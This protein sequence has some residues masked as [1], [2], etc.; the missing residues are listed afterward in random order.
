[1]NKPAPGVRADRLVLLGALREGQILMPEDSYANYRDYA[2]QARL[3]RGQG[4]AADDTLQ[5]VLSARFW[6]EQLG[7]ASHVIGRTG[8]LNGHVAEIVGVSEVFPGVLFT[9][10]AG[11]L[12]PIGSVCARVQH[13][14]ND[15][16]PHRCGVILI[17]RFAPNVFRAG[18]CGRQA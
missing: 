14:T 5:V 17:G 16:G 3:E 4:F 11:R 2:A 6:R 1:L 8:N 12:G 13:T 9:E 18:G 15:R 7:G 10:S